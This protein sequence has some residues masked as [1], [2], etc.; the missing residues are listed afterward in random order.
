MFN[1]LQD[2]NLKKTLEQHFAR[3]YE[4]SRWESCQ[5]CGWH[6]SRLQAH[7]Q[8]CNSKWPDGIKPKFECP[9]K[10]GFTTTNKDSLRSHYKKTCKADPD[11]EKLSWNIY[12]LAFCWAII[13]RNASM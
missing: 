1:V 11:K 6:F 12:R 4:M 5:D 10:C 9:R 13:E 7:I 8:I 2:F 3:E